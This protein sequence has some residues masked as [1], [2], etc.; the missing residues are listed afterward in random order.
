M[1]HTAC[2]KLPSLD[3]CA[4]CVSANKRY[5]YIIDDITDLFWGRRDRLHLKLLYDCA[6]EDAKSLN[7]LNPVLDAI[8]N[9]SKAIMG[10]V[11]APVLSMFIKGEVVFL[12][13]WAFPEFHQCFSFMSRLQSLKR[14][15]DMSTENSPLLSN[16]T[17]SFFL[18]GKW[19]V[20]RSSNRKYK[21]K[22][23]LHCCEFLGILGVDSAT[24]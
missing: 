10:S 2:T 21:V 7:D 23:L 22:L 19:H 6:F 17:V 13:R 18:I 4:P 8:L 15:T 11:V 12:C 3:W 24:S 9:I 20:R 16:E 14:V 5:S 1:P